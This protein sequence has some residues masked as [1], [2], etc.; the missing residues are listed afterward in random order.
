MEPRIP[1]AFRTLL[2]LCS[3]KI[4]TE[5]GECG[6]L[7][8]SWADMQEPLLE[9]MCFTLKYLGMTLV[10]KPKGEDMAAAAIRRIVATARV[11]ARKFQKVILTVSPRGI[12]LQ[13][14]DTKEMV[15]NISIYRISYC[16][17]DKLQNKVFAYVAQSQESGALECHAFLSPKKKIAQAVTLTVAQAFQMALDLWEAANAGSRQEQPLHPPCVLERSEPSRAS[18]PAPPGSPPFR[19]QFGEP[20]NAC[21]LT[22]C[23]QHWPSLAVVGAIVACSV[24]QVVLCLVL[25]LGHAHPAPVSRQRCAVCSS[26]LSLVAHP[27]FT[28]CVWCSAGLGNVRR[29]LVCLFPCVAVS[30]LQGFHQPST[31]GAGDSPAAPEEALGI[32]VWILVETYFSVCL[33]ACLQGGGRGGGR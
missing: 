7:P 33:L 3:S 18:E 15:E 4:V 28:P 2:S 5:P 14:A 31:A 12:S 29:T 13:D 25:Q 16:T 23:F 27:Q 17:T 22:S 1:F 26:H 8:E 9:G 10:E 6:E 24:L 11:G 20:L 19:H 30:E 32:P 21:F